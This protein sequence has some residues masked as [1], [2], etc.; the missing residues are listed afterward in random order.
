VPFGSESL[1]DAVVA[2]QQVLHGPATP[3]RLVLPVSG[4]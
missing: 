4:G 1:A 2:T 3:S